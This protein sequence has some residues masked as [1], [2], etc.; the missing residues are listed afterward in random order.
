MLILIQGFCPLKIKLLNFLRDSILGHVLTN[1]HIFKNRIIISAI[2]G[3][4]DSGIRENDVYGIRNPGFWNR[5]YSSRI[6]ESY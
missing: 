6:P 5:E 1:P 3:T 2:K 4:P